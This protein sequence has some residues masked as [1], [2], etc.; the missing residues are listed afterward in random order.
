M[1]DQ[2][3]YVLCRHILVLLSVKNFTIFTRWIQCLRT[4]IS[5][6]SIIK[7]DEISFTRFLL[8][9]KNEEYSPIQTKVAD[10]IEVREFVKETIGESY[11]IPVIGVFAS[12]SDIDFD[13]LPSSYIIKANHGSGWNFIKREG[14]TIDNVKVKSILNS[15]LNRNAYYLSRETQYRSIRPGLIIEHLIGD[16]PTDYKIFCFLGKAKCVQV[17]TNR[18]TN[19]QRTLFDLKWEELPI[20]IRYS[21]IDP[22]PRKP[23]E[24]MEL[25]RIAE[26]LALPF[27]F[28]RVDLYLEQGRIF[29]GEITLMPGGGTEP[30]WSYEE[31][32][33][34]Y[35]VIVG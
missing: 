8:N 12:A 28:C 6:Y 5:Y 19:H 21:K 14:D 18:F 1:R 31:D 27:S 15:W 35:N 4:G 33:K 7:R 3:W 20:S 16:N 23:K 24:L 11:L 34:M 13:G 10:K 9:L 30:F 25:I 17:D 22:K 26:K 32:V 2:I 29:F